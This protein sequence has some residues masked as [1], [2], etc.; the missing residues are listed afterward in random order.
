ME[1]PAKN[2]PA[3]PVQPATSEPPKEFLARFLHSF[4]P[5][6]PLPKLLKNFTL[7]ERTALFLVLLLLVEAWFVH[8]TRDVHVRKRSHCCFLLLSSVLFVAIIFFTRMG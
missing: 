1:D 2:T 8:I 4:A 6:D 3:P 7:W 5:K